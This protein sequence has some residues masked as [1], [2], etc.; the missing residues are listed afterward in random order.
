MQELRQFTRR[1]RNVLANFFSAGVS[2]CAKNPIDLG[3]VRQFPGQCV[4]TSATADDEN[5]HKVERASG[6]NEKQ[7]RRTRFCASL[8]D[9][10][11]AALVPAFPLASRRSLVVLFV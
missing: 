3:R 6:A 4:F 9:L 7:D 8:F 11:S 1:N 2:R 10:F 5:L